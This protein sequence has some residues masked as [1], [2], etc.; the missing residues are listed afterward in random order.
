MG[1]SAG[2]GSSDF[3]ARNGL[4]PQKKGSDTHQASCHH[5]G[6]SLR[7]GRF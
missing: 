3:T 1:A 2:V 7:T 5:A 4:S 6:V